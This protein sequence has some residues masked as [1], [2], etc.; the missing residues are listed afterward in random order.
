MWI[1]RRLLQFL[2][3][4]RQFFVS[5]IGEARA[6]V[7]NDGVIQ[8]QRAIAHRQPLVLDFLRE[9]FD[10]EFMHQDLDACLVDVVTAA[11]LVVDPQDRLDIAQDIAPRHERLYR[12]ADE[13]RAAKSAADQHLKAGLAFGVLVQAEPDVVHFYGRAIVLGR[14]NRKFELARQEGEF[15]MQRRILPQ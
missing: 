3:H 7:L 2:R 1:V 10:A 9:F 8:R 6:D 5:R 15:R 14:G 11:V 12:F 13:G 4:M